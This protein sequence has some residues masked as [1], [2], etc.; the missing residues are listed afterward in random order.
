MIERSSTTTTTTE[1]AIWMRTSLNKPGGEQ[2][3]QGGY[4]LLVVVGVADAERQR[5]ED[6]AGIGA[7]ESLHANVGQLKRF[8]RPGVGA[9]QDRAQETRKARLV[10]NDVR[11]Q[12]IRKMGRIRR[13]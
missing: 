11:K 1:P 2:G 10:R 7:L 8:H 4:A 9:K 12:V 5:C 13:T 6:R 3:A